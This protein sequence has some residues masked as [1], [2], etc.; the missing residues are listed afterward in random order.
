MKRSV[1]KR[2]LSE[3]L[4]DGEKHLARME[5]DQ[6]ATRKEKPSP[7]RS[8]RLEG[9]AHQIG[10]MNAVIEKTNAFLELLDISNKKYKKNAK[11][12]RDSLKQAKKQLRE[13]IDMR[14]K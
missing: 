14:V 6:K 7:S 12:S 5:K 8:D 4:R 3:Q 9:L 2:I 1:I 13:A 11:A 10:Y